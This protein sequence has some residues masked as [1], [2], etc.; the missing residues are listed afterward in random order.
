MLV[1]YFRPT[2]A[3]YWDTRPYLH[4]ELNTWSNVS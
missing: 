3:I 2:I 4:H 1:V